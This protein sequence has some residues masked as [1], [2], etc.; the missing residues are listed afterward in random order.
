MVAFP[1]SK[2]NLGLNVL[3]RRDD[4]Y[5]DIDTCFYPVP[6]TDIL[7]LVPGEETSFTSTG[8][9]IPGPRAENLCVKAFQ[10]LQKK[11][12]IPGAEIH[13]HKIIPTGAG[14]GGGSS[15]AAHTLRLANEMFSLNL[16]KSDLTHYASLLGSDCPFFL[17]DS[18]MMGAGRGEVL[19]PT[20]IDLSGKYL[21]LVNPGLHVS[22]AEAY[23]GISP[24]YPDQP[25]DSILSLP[26]KE[27][28][29]E[30]VNDFEESVFKRFPLIRDIK[31]YLYATGALYA[32]MSGSGSSVYAL[33]ETEPMRDLSTIDPYMLWRGYL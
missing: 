15:D 25:L 18:P 11:H 31:E 26:V 12:S 1:P 19:S 14:L 6:F 20:T 29:R 23:A 32:S 10:L 17:F 2:I 8:L 13:L 24:R 28:K 4:G 30:L 22:T 5:H 16:A 33:Y 27:W 9:A 7:E 3:E 21:L